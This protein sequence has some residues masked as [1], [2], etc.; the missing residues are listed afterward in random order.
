MLLTKT[1][2]LPHVEFDPDLALEN[3][4]KIH[5]EIEYIALSSVT[6]DGFDQW[7]ALAQ[8]PR[9]TNSCK[10]RPLRIPEDSAIIPTWT[11]SSQSGRCAQSHRRHRH[12]P[13]RRLSPLRLPT[14]AR[15]AHLT[16]FI[17]NTPAGV[18]IEVQGEPDKLDRF[19]QR[20]PA[21]NSSTGQN[22]FAVAARCG[23]AIRIRLPHRRQP[24]RR[25]SQSPYLPGRRRLR[26]LPARNAQSSRPPLPLSLHQ[27]HQ[28]RPAL[29]HHSRY[30]LR[31]R[32]HLHGLVSNVSPPARPNT[33]IPPIAASMPSPMPAGT[34]VRKCN[35]RRPMARSMMS[36]SRFAKPLAFSITRA[37]SPSRASAGFT[38]P[39]MPEF[40]SDGRDSPGTQAP[41]RKALRRHASPHRRCSTASAKP[42]T[43]R[44]NFFSPLSGP[45]CFF[46]ASLKFW[47]RRMH[48]PA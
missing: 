11:I 32:P 22:H 25:A 43:P 10:L 41:R 34:A 13:G 19:L 47:P 4:R 14:R 28:L 17:A 21:G 5:P 36:P 35:S 37:S 39:A 3:A 9:N 15:N 46:P 42:M 45:S 8:C 24:S 18:T 26:R 40:G 48:R 2:L 16:G 31:P 30:S 7:L 20:L 38:L 1:D 44:A 27:L 6:G 29:H 23:A 33:T 12:R